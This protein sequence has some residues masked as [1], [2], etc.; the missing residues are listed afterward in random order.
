MA[1]TA[2]DVRR[3]LTETRLRMDATAAELGDVVSERIEHAKRSIDPRHY[4][5]EFP[6]A[7]LGLAL[8]AGLAI[9]LSGADR[10]AGGLVVAS[11]KRTVTT[12]ADGALSAK[13]AIVERVRGGAGDDSANESAQLTAAPAGIRGKL[14]TALDDLLYVGL[15]GI[16]IGI[17]AHNRHPSRRPSS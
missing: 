2:E 11:A 14:A 4:A 15:Q 8:G 10:T 16:L 3:E 5:R 9:G 13:D 17:L 6:W 1:A 12:I 7:T